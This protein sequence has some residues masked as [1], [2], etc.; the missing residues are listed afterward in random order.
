MLC[1]TA[2]G[3]AASAFVRRGW[4][5]MVMAVFVRAIP[6]LIFGA[7]T[8]YQLGWSASWR[9]VRYPPLAMADGGTAP[10]FQLVQP[11]TLWTI[12]NHANAVYG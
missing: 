1:C 2:L 10:L 9:I 6:V 11:V 8:A 5:A 3:L 12:D 4:A 7:L